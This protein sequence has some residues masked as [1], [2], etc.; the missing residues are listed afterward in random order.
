VALG[1]DQVDGL[2]D[3]SRRGASSRVSNRGVSYRDVIDV[4]AK[5][6]TTMT[7]LISVNGLLEAQA[8]ALKAARDASLL[9]DPRLALMPAAHLEGFQQ[10]AAFFRTRPN[11]AASQEAVVA[12][13]RQTVA[14]IAAGGGRIVA[15]S[16][17]PGVPYGAAF[18]AELEQFVEAG[19]TPFQALQSATLG[20]AEALG[21]DDVLGSIEPGKSA[22]LVFVAGDPLRDIRAARDVRHVIRGGRDYDLAALIRR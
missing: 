1:V 14:A 2:R 18:H 21:V 5:S 3:V 13:L 22:D 8:F 12:A 17:A 15:G 19:L 11:D 20:A 4:I 10:A 16:G 6:A 7:P 9:G